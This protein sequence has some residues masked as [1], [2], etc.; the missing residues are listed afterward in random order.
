MSSKSL[1]RLI[2]I[3]FA[4]TIA[5]LLMLPASLV[6]AD[7][8]NSEKPAPTSGGD[9]S[10]EGVSV[11]KNIYV[12]DDGTYTIEL[13]AFSTGN[14]TTTT[15]VKPCDIV[16][17]LDASSSMGQ[18]GSSY[19]MDD[20]TV[21][22]QALVD[23][24]NTFL[25]TVAE[26][27]A[28]NA[29]AG[30]DLS[31]V[32]IVV[33]SDSSN[34]GTLYN[35]T[36]I[37]N[38]NLVSNSVYS[39]YS[40]RTYTTTGYGTNGKGFAL[41]NYTW[42]DSGLSQANTLLQTLM[43]SANYN[44]ADR[45][46]VVVMFTDGYPNHSG[47]VDG[48]DVTAA[49][50][51]ITNAATIKTSRQA[52]FFS[53]AVL[54]NVAQPERNPQT[55]SQA[56]YGGQNQMRLNQMLH[57]ASSNYPQ[58]SVTGTW[59]MNWGSGGNYQA[60]YYKSAKTASDLKD[61]FKD[62]AETSASTETPLTTE[63]I[64]K[65]IVSSSFTLPEG[66]D[67]NT[68]KVTI[69]P[70][71]STNHRWSATG[72]TAAQWATQC[73]NYGAESSE[74][75]SVA[76]SEDGKT[77]DV[78]G[79]DYGT[80]FL[81]TS[82][83]TQDINDVNKD[84]AK[85]HIEFPIQARPSAVTG[86]SV[87]TNGDK[88]G[89]YLDGN[90]TEPLI[91]FPQ[92]EVVFT[93]V[94]Y[95]VDYVTSDTSTDTKASTVKLDYSKVL[96]NVQML[97]DPSDDVLIG[98]DASEF[99]YTIYK[100]QYGTISFGDDVVDVQRR[101]VRYAPTTMNWD[102]YDRI[103]VK[104]ESATESDLDVW[105][106]LCVVPANSV[107]YEDTYVTQTKT[108]TYNE[109]EVTIEYT[110]IGYTGTWNTIGTEGKNQT[111]HANKDAAGNPIPQG[112][113]EGLSDDSDFANDMA[114]TSSTAKAKATFTFS[115]TGVDIYSRTNGS[116]GIISVALK[117]LAEDNESGK[118]IIKSKV[119]DNKAAAGDFY[120]VPVCTFTDLPYG[121][122]T[123]TITVTTGGKAEGRMTFYLDGVRVYNPIK[124]LEGEGNIIAMYGEKNLGAVFT[125]VRSLLGTG[126]EA[127]ALYIDE[128]TT[129]EVVS[130][131]DAIEAA[132]NALAEAQEAY[133]TYVEENVTP[134]KNAISTAE[135]TLQAAKDK[136]TNTKNI[137]DVAKD[138]YDTAV[139]AGESAETIAK[140]EAEMNTAKD[141][142]DDAAADAVTAQATYD[143]EIPGLQAALAT[144]IEGKNTYVAAIEAARTAYDTAN[145]AVEVGYN[146]E[147]VVA[148]YNK[149]GPNS[150]L[151]LSKNQ[152]VAINVE[153][154]KYY[155]I[156]LRSLNGDKVTCTING[157]EKELSHTVDLYYEAT[158]TEGNTIVIKNTGNA[159]L[160][161]T[162]LR[163]TGEDNTTNGV[164]I[165]STEKT[166]AFVKSLASRPAAAYVGEILTEEEATVEET[167]VENPAVE[168]ETEVTLEESD[169]TIENAEPV[170]ENENAETGIAETEP[171]PTPATN[172]FTNVLSRLMSSFS[173]FFRR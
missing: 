61:I 81:A 135:H 106:M 139:A 164:T 133:D 161:V 37:T 173:R 41:H 145:E 124:P 53:I 132:A 166:L 138:A 172:S 57:A 71:D 97:D 89:I 118:K 35:F 137:Y 3:A 28:E 16:L 108:V 160:S 87:K 67:A 82:D 11:S 13:D 49:R 103:F 56:T 98:Q 93:P 36:E 72:Y 15:V 31:R 158:P 120:A 165:A 163:T 142:W 51:V 156:G 30:S 155:F 170:A 130:D 68:I 148:D 85:V 153:S 162:K 104:G 25:A 29:A 58:A 150:E 69:V 19:L 70:W 5:F 140:L 147:Q 66:A 95:V 113:I 88:S 2:K 144:A 102:G 94:T 12:E 44:A 78:T 74:N 125:E 20:G 21:R 59:N 119:I 22:I 114:H 79:F 105:A 129:S 117:S 24:V 91:A 110:G 169:I 46:R 83:P 77:I 123:A 9:A 40:N 99:I 122:Y 112:W 65:D 33:F 76:I 143:A 154:G 38:E 43:N 42:T 80:H 157:A 26:K 48:F 23:A 4:L 96:K 149:D 63:S 64:M 168:T 127:A 34:T 100:G 131:L 121:K 8:E 151:Y 73:L 39:T 32:A 111:Q 54:G 10:V 116:T 134:A 109:Q 50:S 146:T 90:A 6:S 1:Y 92:P 60:G 126:A 45:N 167:V 107:F 47:G 17:V 27:N 101:Y 7:E 14:V 75:V 84:S 18:T 86:G 52:T 115:G 141:N 128:H 62:I 159:I 136:E 55:T 171:V 152:Q